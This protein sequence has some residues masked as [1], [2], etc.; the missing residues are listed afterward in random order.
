MFDAKE[1]DNLPFHEPWYSRLNR[2]HKLVVCAVLRVDKL[3]ELVESFVSD[4]IGY[5][6]VEPVQFDLGRI[7]SE[8]DPSQ[9]L[10]YT[11]KGPNEAASDIKKFAEEKEKSL[12]QFSMGGN[13]EIAIKQMIFKTL[14]SGEK[15]I[16]LENF[17][18]AHD[19]R[20]MLK[21][22][23]KIGM[24]VLCEQNLDYILDLIHIYRLE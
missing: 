5:K 24:Y 14:E 15:W 20:S 2:F 11:V 17:Q 22:H 23:V 21:H 16:L 18:N 13:N 1:P 9:P 12:A 7:F 4:H 19:M 6:F 10:L 3:P 8:T